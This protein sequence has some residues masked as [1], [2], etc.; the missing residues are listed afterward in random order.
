MPKFAPGPPP[1]GSQPAALTGFHLS[2]FLPFRTGFAPLDAAAVCFAHSIHRTPP[3]AFTLA[4]PRLFTP[5]H[6]AGRLAPHPF[7]ALPCL[8]AAP[9]CAQP[10]CL[11]CVDRCHWTPTHLL[12]PASTAPHPTAMRHTFAAAVLRAPGPHTR[13]R[14][15][16]FYPCGLL[17]YACTLRATD[18]FLPACYT[19]SS[20]TAPVPSFM[21]LRH[22]HCYLPATAWTACL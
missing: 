10:C 8:L 16:A 18:T 21:P 14:T 20:T 13:T 5:D 4:A 12:R 7:S 17:P 22:I 1:A 11:R 2:P 19:S 15:H 3:C 9:C 6:H